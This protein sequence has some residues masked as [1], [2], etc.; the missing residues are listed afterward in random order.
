VKYSIS[1]LLVL[2]FVASLLL[3]IYPLV[4]EEL[5]EF[6]TRSTYDFGIASGD[7]YGLRILFLNF[8]EFPDDKIEDLISGKLDPMTFKLPKSYALEIQEFVDGDPWGRPYQFV[9]RADKDGRR[10]FFSFGRDGKSLTSGNDPDDISTWK[11]PPAKYYLEEHSNKIRG[12]RYLIGTYLTLI[13]FGLFWFF[14]DK[15][16][17]RRV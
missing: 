8:T 17:S 3:C 5:E 6:T 16:R 9:E 15:F 13:V 4:D 7:I 2:T 11:T 14:A 12:R 1:K 10:H